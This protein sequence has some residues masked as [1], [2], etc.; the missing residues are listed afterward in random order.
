MEEFTKNLGISNHDF[1]LII[2][3]TKIDYDET[4]EH[5]NRE[6]HGYSLLSA[7]HLLEKQLLLQDTRYFK[8]SEPFKE[9]DEVRHM[10]MGLDDSRNIVLM[11]TT[12]RPGETVRVISFRRASDKE[13]ETFIKMT[14]YNKSLETDA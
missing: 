8:T 7:V 14:G 13:R 6:K 10:H 3:R 11:V 2:G 12:M 1:R 4:K 5:I 9:N